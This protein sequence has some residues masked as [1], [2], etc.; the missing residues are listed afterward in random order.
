MQ[1]ELRSVTWGALD[2]GHMTDRP[3]PE[4]PS[5]PP[6]S[7]PLRFNQYQVHIVRRRGHLMF[8]VSELLLFFK[9]ENPSIPH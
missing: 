9:H 1:G 3:L 7:P 4:Q 2:G 8:A 5:L 6:I